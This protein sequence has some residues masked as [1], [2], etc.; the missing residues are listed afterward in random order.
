MPI[1]DRYPVNFR[2]ISNR[3]LI[4]SRSTPGQVAAHFFE[5][6][7]YSL[8]LP[9]CAYFEHPESLVCDPFP[10]DFRSIS[11][12][13]RPLSDRFPVDF[14]QNRLGLPEHYGFF[15]FL[16]EKAL[17]QQVVLDGVFA[18]PSGGANMTMQSQGSNN[19]ATTRH[20]HKATRDS[21]NGIL[22]MAEPHASRKDQ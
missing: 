17:V 13:F 20:I 7:F 14:M 1:S 6:L 15:C 22:Y 12:A 3:F 5:Y 8:H 9:R 19:P 16:V 10:I 2:S 11:T 18:H 21:A 4:D